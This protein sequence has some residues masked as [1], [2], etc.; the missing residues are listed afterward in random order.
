MNKE[1]LADL[2]SA[3][4]YLENAYYELDGIYGATTEKQMVINDL[5]IDVEVILEKIND[6]GVL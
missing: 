2:K 6:L 4:T 5:A 1:Q 3:K